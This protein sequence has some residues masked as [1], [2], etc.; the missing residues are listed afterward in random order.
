MWEMNGSI[1]QFRPKE[2]GTKASLIESGRDTM[3]APSPYSE[4][5]LEL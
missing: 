5:N 4:T 1:L 2:S 3:V